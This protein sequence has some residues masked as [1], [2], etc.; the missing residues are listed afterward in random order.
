MQNKIIKRNAQSSTELII[1]ITMFL[2]V[3][4]FFFYFGQN[5]LFDNTTA[6]GIS[7]VKNSL[8]DIVNEIEN[9]YQQ[10][11]GASSK[12]LI[13]LPDNIDSAEINNSIIKYVLNS[14]KLIYK[15]TN[16]PVIGE[17]PV[18][19]PTW[20]HIVSLEG[21]V[22]VYYDIF[23]VTP[24]SIH[25]SF[26]ETN[27]SIKT[28]TINNLFNEIIDFNITYSGDVEIPM[29]LSDNILLIPGKGFS[30]FNL[31]ITVP[32]NTSYGRYDG[33]LRVDAISRDTKI[34]EN[35]SIPITVD[36]FHNGSTSLQA[37]IGILPNTW[38]INPAYPNYEQNSEFYVYSGFNITKNVS[39]NFSGPIADWFSFTSWSINHTTD[40]NLSILPEYYSSFSIYVKPENNSLTG[41]YTS[42]VNYYYNRTIFEQTELLTGQVEINIELFEDSNPP[43][44]ENITI[45]KYVFELGESACIYADVIDDKGINSIELEYNN[46]DG[47]YIVQ[48][49]NGSCEE[50]KYSALIPLTKIGEYGFGNITAHDYAE[51]VATAF[52]NISVDVIFAIYGGGFNGTIIENPDDSCWLSGG[53]TWNN[54]LV[55]FIGDGL[56]VAAYNDD[57]D[58][59]NCPSESYD[60]IQ[61]NFDNLSVPNINITSFSVSLTHNEDRDDGVLPSEVESFS[62]RS[63]FQ[64]F[65]GTNWKDMQIMPIS[66]SPINF[67]VVDIS[68]CVK[69]ADI[70][71]N[72]SLRFIFD[73]VNSTD[74]YMYLDSITSTILTKEF[75][76]IDLWP[77]ALF[78]TR[79]AFNALNSIDNTF[80]IDAAANFIT[81]NLLQNS[82]FINLNSWNT[83]GNIHHL[84]GEDTVIFNEDFESSTWN[85]NWTVSQGGGDIIRDTDEYAGVYGLSF[86][87]FGNGKGLIYHSINL[88]S[89]SSPTLEF[90]YAL[91]SLE[92]G[93]EAFV[94]IYD[95]SWD[96]GVF[97]FGPDGSVSPT[98]PSDYTLESLDLSSYDLIDDFRIQFRSSGKHSNDM[99]LIDEISVK[100]QGGVGLTNFFIVNDSF[101][102]VDQNF[103]LNK[104]PINVTLGITHSGSEDNFLGAAFAFCNLTSSGGEINVWNETWTSDIHNGSPISEIIDISSIVNSTN[105]TYNIECG[106][107]VG[108]G[109][110]I[111]FDDIWINI[112]YVDSQTNDGWDWADAIYDDDGTYGSTFITHGDPSG[113]SDTTEPNQISITIG[114]ANSGISEG[115]ASGAWG[116]EFT[117]DEETWEKIDNNEARALLSLE[118]SVIDLLLST[119]GVGMGGVW[120]KSRITHEDTINYL[121]TNIDNSI[122]STFNY[123]DNTKELW[124]AVDLL[125]P[126]W[127][128]PAM[129]SYSEDISQ[130]ITSSGIYFIDFGG[131]IS[132]I[133]GVK[134][135]DE[136][137]K[138]TFDNIRLLIEEE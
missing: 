83:N 132:W 110:T 88:S 101:G 9:V 55:Q 62:S 52:S 18:T 134:Y 10:G 107:I 97:I 90:Y 3:F 35:R 138:F 94:D 119:S 121:G 130:Y 56:E 53:N 28:F 127:N 100:T 128:S 46:S 26:F 70:A 77:D 86:S 111:A 69:N 95:G 34:I 81:I 6:H 1:V 54:N 120:V 68:T 124:A 87:G 103:T 123:N 36:L 59:G 112:T 33:I 73:P 45:Y 50:S 109:T 113:I 8:Q 25:E 5:K 57:W 63:M 125:Y 114:G 105:F 79:V 40:Y 44:I 31:N 27:T 133:G 58:L 85:T 117:I 136:G 91:E 75:S 61:F 137:V 47:S 78:D 99:F 104:D 41:N 108:A 4:S 49:T 29:V 93:D 64:C 17:V 60:Y 11:S 37:V 126:G 19:G 30:S 65:N 92:S 80:Y 42:Y 32:E 2:L 22:F 98:S 21:Y 115:I 67:D 13:Y 96:N 39:L 16:V 15:N 118:Y 116:I 24:S 43:I 135:D 82:E 74:A 20:V 71:N 12:I 89:V 66:L 23:D 131:K 102:S 38:N 48:L 129:R 7:M 72:L 106:A 84:V 76:L 14:G 122:E 51:N